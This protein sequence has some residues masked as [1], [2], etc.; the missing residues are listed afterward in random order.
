MKMP[1]SNKDLFVAT[2]SHLHRN[3]LLWVV[4]LLLMTLSSQAA[5]QP[6]DANLSIRNEIQR[7]IDRGLVWLEKNQNKDGTWSTGDQPALTALALLAFKGEPNGRYSKD[8]PEFI[9]RSYAFLES[10][11]QPDGSIYKKQQYLT[12]N[13]ALSILAFAASD[14]PKYNSVIRKGREFLIGLQTDFDTKGKADNVFDGGVGYGSKYEHSDMANTLSALEAIYYT[15]ERLQDRNVDPGKDLDWAAAIQFLQNCQNLPSHNKQEWV[16]DD[17]QNKGGFVYYPGHSMAGETNIAGRVAFRSYGSASYA[18]LLSYIYADLKRDDPR[19]RAVYDWLRDNYTL[20]ENPGMGAQGLYY[21]FHTMAKAL[22]AMDVDEIKMTSGKPV[23][24]RKE[25]AFKL[26]NLQ[27]PDG[28][29]VNDN[30]RWWETDFV[31]V[32]AYAVIALERIHRA[33][34]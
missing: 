6:R 8:E 34:E 25:L 30:G 2:R 11:V 3:L 21:Y 23:D 22:T 12:H 5:P 13:T 20:E 10:C 1:N 7:A 9:K 33:L 24:W 4:A 29:W 31:L 18:G 27:R 28:S 15:R 32:T 14:D 17:P 26:I 16:S 19:V